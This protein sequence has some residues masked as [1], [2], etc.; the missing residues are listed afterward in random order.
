MRMFLLDKIPCG[1]LGELFAGL[2]GNLPF[3]CCLCYLV[4]DG[5]LQT[6]SVNLLSKRPSK[7]IHPVSLGIS[8]L[9]PLAFALVGKGR[10]R[11]RYYNLNNLR[12]MCFHRSQY[13]LGSLNGR[14]KKLLFVVFN[15]A[16]DERRGGMNDLLV[17]R[18][19]QYPCK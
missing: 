3:V 13:T 15:P 9:R 1:L 14:Q 12:A 4:V 6:K 8:V 10:K 16:C 11:R 17:V 18:S 5:I 19:A 7:V 2:V